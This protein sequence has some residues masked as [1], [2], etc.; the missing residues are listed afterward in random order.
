M[1]T[2][3]QLAEAQQ[4]V[5]DYR[6]AAARMRRNNASTFAMATNAHVLNAHSVNAHVMTEAHLTLNRLGLADVSDA[7]TKT[8]EALQQIA[9]AKD[10][11]RPHER[12]LTQ[13][14]EAQRVI[15]G[16]LR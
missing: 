11:G 16:A 15:R 14:R 2:P 13:R 5:N 9:S 12:W 1:M 8:H 6:R 4:A 10:E 3:E 7:L